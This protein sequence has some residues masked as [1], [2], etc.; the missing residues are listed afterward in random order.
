VKA[1]ATGTTSGDTVFSMLDELN[2]ARAVARTCGDTEYAAQ[3]AL[4]W[5]DSLAEIAMIHSMD[6]AARGYFAHDTLDG[7]SFTERVWPY[8]NGRTIGENI[9]AASN[10]RDDQSVIDMW[11]DSPGHCALIMSPNFTHAGIGFGHDPSVGYR[12]VYYFWTLDVGG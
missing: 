11:L 12:G 5:S 10:D 8:W 6:M 3:P 1:T 9:A 4:Q 7:P 2:A